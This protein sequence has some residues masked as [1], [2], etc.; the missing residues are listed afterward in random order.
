MADTLESKTTEL[1]ERQ[2]QPFKKLLVGLELG[3]SDAS[4][5]KYLQVLIQQFSV[6]E[7]HFLHVVPR[8]RYIVPIRTIYPEKLAD[9]SDETKAD[10]RQQMVK[11]VHPFVP[12]TMIPEDRYSVREGSPLEEMVN[13]AARIKPTTVVMGKKTEADRHVVLAK[14]LLREIDSNLL[15]IPEKSPFTFNQVTVPIDFSEN[16]VRALQTALEM[17]VRVS[18]DPGI[19][20]LHVYQRPIM[21]AYKIE[22]T[23]GQLSQNTAANQLEAFNNF[24]ERE[25][26]DQTDH[27][28]PALIEDNRPSTARA[29]LDQ[30]KELKTDLLVIGAKGH[31][32]L[33]RFFLGS[34]T[35]TLLNRADAFPILVIK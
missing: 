2:I 17:K 18:S 6:E 35:E 1:T 10:I 34:T 26:P 7:I 24:L 20:A 33:E 14:N 30:A 3:S 28:K 32:A 12:P 4:L 21:L 9:L 8:H 31:S 13:M 22:M 27:I 16:S 5:L 15:V 11:A 25:L 29:I 19:S 23:P